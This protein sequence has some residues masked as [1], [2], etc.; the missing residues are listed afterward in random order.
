MIPLFFSTQLEFK[1]WLFGNHKKKSELLVG[2][3]KVKS[4]KPSMT[5]SQSVDEALCFGWI[6]GVRKSINN[7]SYCIR[8]TPRKSTSIWSAVNIEKMEKL[9]ES[10]LMQPTGL[11]SFKLRKESKSKI[12]AYE[13]KVVK[14]STKYENIFK[15]NKKAWNFFN[16]QAPSYQKKIIHRIMSAKQEK[17]QI[18]RLEKTITESE[19]LERLN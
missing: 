5:W 16:A 7:E 17:T 6:D 19:K 18:S 4:G 11:A 14:L 8:F 13:N 1:K 15:S 10:G 9:I 12:Y 2:Y 3:Y